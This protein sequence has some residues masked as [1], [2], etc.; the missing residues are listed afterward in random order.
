MAPVAAGTHL[1][2]WKVGPDG[3]VYVHG[4]RRRCHPPPPSQLLVMK[5][6]FSAFG[7]G[8]KKPKMAAGKEAVAVPQLP[9]SLFLLPVRPG[10]AQKEDDG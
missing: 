2:Q 4:G 7:D 8:R 9:S 3:R 5:S 1:L 6:Q 10:R